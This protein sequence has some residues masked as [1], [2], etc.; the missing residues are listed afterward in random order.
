MVG[1][2]VLGEVEV[3]HQHVGVR[4]VVGDG[5]EVLDR[6]DGRA[7]RR[8]DG[9]DVADGVGGLLRERVGEALAHPAGEGAV[10]VGG[11]GA[12]GQH[13][14]D[15]V[16]LARRLA[17][18]EDRALAGDDRRREPEV[19]AAVR[20]RG[21]IGAGGDALRR[22]PDV[23]EVVV[24]HRRDGRVREL[25]LGERGDA[26][27][28]ADVADVAHGGFRRAVAIDEIRVG[29]VVDGAAEGAGSPRLV[30]GVRRR[31]EREAARDRGTGRVV[32]D[33][34]GQDESTLIAILGDGGRSIDGVA[35]LD[36]GSVGDRVGEACANVLGGARQDRA[37]ATADGRADGDFLRE[38]VGGAG[39]H[40]HA[41]GSAVLDERTLEESVCE[42]PCVAAGG[43]AK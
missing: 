34:R 29:G 33:A 13:R 37:H 39:E 2:K 1:G 26:R 36:G 14:A 6:V 42:A 35:V 10:R 20:G 19:R 4:G 22:A 23:L 11:D 12:D 17:V 24:R 31:R 21:E 18:H 41:V 9:G 7:E 25:R 15:R 8:A 30:A 5:E 16:G 32:A 38:P 28:V 43:I 3:V 27:V 40:R